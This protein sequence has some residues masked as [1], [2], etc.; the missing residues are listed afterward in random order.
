MRSHSVATETHLSPKSNRLLKNQ[1]KPNQNQSQSN[2]L[3]DSI[4]P[5]DDISMNENDTSAFNPYCSYV[6]VEKTVDLT[7][8]D[9]YNLRGFGFLLKNGSGSNQ[10]IHSTQNERTNFILSQNYAEIVGLDPRKN[11]RKKKGFEFYH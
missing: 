4:Q 1:P 2:Q 3:N 10:L 9:D 6:F 7:R 11:K 5:S 8:A